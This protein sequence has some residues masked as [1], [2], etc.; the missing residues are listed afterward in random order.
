LPLLR[1]GGAV[2]LVSLD[3]VAWSDLPH[4]FEAGTPNTV[5]AIALGAACRAL[6]EYGMDRIASAEHT[7]AVQL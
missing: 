2:R 4:R 5:G 7:L 3:D 6:A 1:G